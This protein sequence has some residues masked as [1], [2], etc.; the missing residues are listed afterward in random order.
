MFY[1]EFRVVSQRILGEK[2]LKLQLQKDQWRYEAIYFNQAALLPEQ[3]HAVY[4]LQINDY[5][6]QQQVQL[7]LK[8][9]HA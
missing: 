6:G 8:Y 5:Q 3:V 1:D 4:Q 2:H 9:A 7:Q